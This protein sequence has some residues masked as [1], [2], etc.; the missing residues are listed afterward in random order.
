MNAAMHR[1]ILDEM[2]LQ[3]AIDLPQ[4]GTTVYLSAGQQPQSQRSGFATAEGCEYLR[5]VHE[6]LISNKWDPFIHQLR[7]EVVTEEDTR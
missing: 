7:S 2:L 1:H 4:T 5:D 6:F 3:S